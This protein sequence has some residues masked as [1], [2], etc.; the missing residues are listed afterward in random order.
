MKEIS[1]IDEV[2]RA[3]AEAREPAEL[4][5]IANVADAMRHLARRA[6]LGMAAANRAASIRLYAER[7]LGSMLA[8]RVRTGRPKMGTL[9]DHFRLAD[10]GI[11]KRMSARAQALAEV[12]LS[13]F[14]TYIADLIDS[15][16]ELTSR[17]LL[18]HAERRTH[19][20]R[21]SQRVRGG[22]VADLV[23]FAAAGHRV[24]TVLVDPPWP[25]EG[26]SALLPYAA[27][28]IED[29]KT[30]PVAS[31]CAERCHCHIWTLPNS[32]LF[33]AE[34]VLLGWGFRPVAV[35]T[36][37]KTGALGRGGY[38]RHQ[39]EHLVTGVR[40]DAD[41]FDDKGLPSWVEAPRGRHSEK[42]EVIYE[43]VERASPPPRVELFARIRRPGWF[44]W[45]HEVHSDALR[46]VA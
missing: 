27:T 22:T 16:D 20:E 42:P 36:W 24:G 26:A 14:N 6:R 12:P 19:G 7:K 33:R 3:V 44:A 29:L 38:W 32:T 17:G 18:L 40:G 34:E 31:F 35:L 8:D 46:V 25:V 4:V 21:T 23:A 45:G 43:V 11:T 37:L 30:L 39:T 13:I 28:T 2:L 9:G 1:T 41:R 15:E 10:I 5:K